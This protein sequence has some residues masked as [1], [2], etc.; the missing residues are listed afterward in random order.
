MEQHRLRAKTLIEALPYIRRYT[1][2]TFVIKCGGEMMLHEELKRA[3][4]QDIALLRLVGVNPIVVHGGGPQV[5]Q[6]MERLG[7]KPNF[8]AGLRVTDDETMEIAEMVLAGKINKEIVAALTRHG[9]PA[10]G[11]SGRDADLL[12]VRKLT[13]NGPEGEVDLGRV[14]EVERVNVGILNAVVADGFIPVVCTVGTGPDG[15]SYNVNADH[16]AGEIA[17][18]VGAIKLIVLTDVPGVMRDPKNED[19]LI[20]TLTPA[21]AEQL[22]AEG[23][24]ESGMVPK[25]QACLRAVRGGVERAHIIDGRLPHALLM[26]VFTDEGIG[27][28]I[29]NEG[30][31]S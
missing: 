23:V 5:S 24:V 6:W 27:T 25:I 22:V 13:H 17:V 31:G 4:M 14:G 26:E 30:A 11:L 10:V 2:K 1:G 29:L 18:A 8:V 15:L 19:S 16:A 7:K 9:G 20:S 21:Q 12:R 28:M 3:T